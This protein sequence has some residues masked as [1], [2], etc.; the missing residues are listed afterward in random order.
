MAKACA[1]PVIIYHGISK[2]VIQKDL[3]SRKNNIKPSKIGERKIV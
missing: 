2:A 1:S 3:M